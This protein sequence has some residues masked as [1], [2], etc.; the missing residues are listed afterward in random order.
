[1]KSF[2]KVARILALYT[3]DRPSLSISE[4]QEELDLP[5]ST[6]FRILNALEKADFIEKNQDTHRYA[7]GFNLFRLGSIVQN[8]M[9][10]RS[11]A[12]PVM[13]RVVKETEETVELN[14]I[15]G[16]SR[17]CVEKVDSPLDVRNFI[18]VGER[19]PL[20]K[21][22]SGKVLLAFL[23]EAEQQRVIGELSALDDSLDTEALRK[24][25]EAIKKDGWCVTRGERVVGSFAVSAPVFGLDGKMMAS[26]TIAG[27]IQR[28]AEG[29]E[30]ELIAAI[31]GGAEALSNRLGY[32]ETP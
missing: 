26:L 9:D 13:N 29:R 32:F 2:E 5:K 20:D 6:I 16:L 22:A 14:I 12:V 3:M 23:A 25:L 7:L 27:P 30:N 8:Q 11:V 15:D 18:R 10:F 24:Q 21:G 1:M 19:K 28:L 4:I 17:I 31:K